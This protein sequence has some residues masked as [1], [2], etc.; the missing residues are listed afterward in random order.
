[1]TI[2]PGQCR[3]L[4]LE[5]GGAAVSSFVSVLIGGGIKTMDGSVRVVGSVHGLARVFGHGNRFEI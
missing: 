1:M 2:I 4:L 3:L 5:E